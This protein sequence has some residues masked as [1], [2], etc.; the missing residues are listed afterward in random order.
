MM[1]ADLRSRP[2]RAARLCGALYFYIIAAGMFAELYVRARLVDPRDGAATAANLVAHETLFRAGASGELLHVALD[3]VVAV[4]LYGL[5]RHVDRGLA[6]LAA[7]TRTAADIVLGVSSLAHFAAL[8]LLNAGATG[9]GLARAEREELALV[10]LRVHG[11]GYAICLIFFAF[12]CLAL[13]PLVRRSGFLP[14]AIG[15]MLSLA[16][17]CYLATSFAH[18]L[19]PRLA[20]HLFPWLFLPPFVA[21]L[22]LALWLL[23]RGGDVARWREGFE[24]ST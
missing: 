7:L 13:G 3:V 10:V 24:A 2:Q 17:A 16:G 14:R 6:R 15:P 21:E 22:S 18:L 12:T 9:V 5:L 8:R 4:L 23:V 19:A 1:I 20:G 11:D